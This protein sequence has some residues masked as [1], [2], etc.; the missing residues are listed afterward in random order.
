MNKYEYAQEVCEYINSKGYQTEITNNYRNNGS[1]VAI[2]V[3]TSEDSRVSPV[4]TI[5]DEAEDPVIFAQRI[6]DFIPAEIDTNVLE[7]IMLDREAVLNRSYYILV[8]SELNSSRTSLVRRPINKTLEL[9]YKADVSD[10]LDG[11]RISL[12]Y[13]HIERLGITENELYVRAYANT[14]ERYPYQLMSMGEAI[15]CDILDEV[16]QMY[17]LTNNRKVNGAG[18]ILYKGMREVLENEV[19][20]DFIV[21]PSSVHEMIIIPAILG[22]RNTIA[23]MIRD[24]NSSCVS[25]EDILSDR[26]YELITDGVLFEL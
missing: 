2:T 25:P 3:R 8:N 18:A 23:T 15:G 11:G 26:P 6:L 5:G 10:I 12:E 4:F 24:V 9:Q 19:G 17:V 13:K 20:G 7:D 21:I 16:P 22:E 1:Y 14:M